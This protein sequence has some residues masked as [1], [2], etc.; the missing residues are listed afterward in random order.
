MGAKRQKPQDPKVEALREEGSLNP[1]PQDVADPAFQDDEFFDPRD[2]VQVKY[3]MVRRVRTEGRTV[4]EATRAFGFSRPTFYVAKSAL[5]E[6]G[7][8][9]LIPKK[10]GP[11]GGHKVT[12]EVLEYIREE[13]EKNPS[14]RT[15][16]LLK[17]LEDRFGLTVHR[18]T[19]E[20]SVERSKKKRR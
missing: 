11:R 18:R 19:M 8:P 20:R 9:G 17:L 4:T 12:P 3:E 6:E 7:L 13:R 16:E 2:L 14:I 15:Q 5:Q 10:R 1:R